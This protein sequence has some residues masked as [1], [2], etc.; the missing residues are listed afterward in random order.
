MRRDRGFTLIEMVMVLFVAGVM[1][2]LGVL[3]WRAAQRN[4]RLS[5]AAN[6]IAV[7]LAGLKYVAISDGVDHLLVFADAPGGDASGCDAFRGATCARYFILRAPAAGW[8]LGAF[9]WED[10]GGGGTAELA[11]EQLLPKGAH[12][13]VVAPP[14][15]MAPPF[16]AV[17]VHDPDLTTT[18]AGDRRCFAIRYTARGD[19]RAELPAGGLAPGKAGYAF[20]LSGDLATA[21]AADQRRGL[22]VSFPAGIL[23]TFV[24]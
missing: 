2:A 22:L 1:A 17:A 16:A 13:E 9:D 8:T 21:N 18:C 11:R 6:E 19:V 20:V 10:P 14:P 5:G 7:R 12:L 23:R 24:F 3:G 4:A 15:P